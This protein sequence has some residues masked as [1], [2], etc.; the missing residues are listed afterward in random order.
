MRKLAMSALFVALLCGSAFAHTGALSLYTDQTITVCSSPITSYESDTIRMYY[1]RDA[2]PD[3]GNAVEFLLEETSGGLVVFL[4][5]EWNSQIQ[6]TLGDP[7][8]G[9]SL[10]ASQ[11]L[12]TNEP[13]VYIGAISLMYLGFGGPF[14]INVKPDPNAQPPAILITE[15]VPGVWPMREVLGGMFVYNGSCNPGVTETSWGAIK[16]L[17]R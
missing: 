14:T 5:Y 7:T 3:L 6:V 4:G 10:T 17:Y 13:I 2:G 16:E 15:C 1:V 8:T 11:C 12:G 9:I